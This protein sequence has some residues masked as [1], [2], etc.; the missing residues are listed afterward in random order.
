MPIAKSKNFEHPDEWEDILRVYSKE[1]RLDDIEFYD[2]L[3]IP[4]VIL[5]RDHGMY[6]FE[7]L[8]SKGRVKMRY[9]NHIHLDCICEISYKEFLVLN[10]KFK[11]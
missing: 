5:K 10:E 7:I 2:N 9:I 11:N 6:K 4:M 3:N 1:I 8:Y